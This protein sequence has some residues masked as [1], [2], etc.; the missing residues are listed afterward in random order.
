MSQIFI[1]HKTEQSLWALLV[2]L[3]L[4]FS[5]LKS[6]LAI[7]DADIKVQPDVTDYLRKQIMKCTDLLVVVD[8]STQKSWWVP[9]EVGIATAEDKRIVTYLPES[10]VH[11]PSYL[12]KWPV[13][14]TA[15]DLET[16]IVAIKNQ[17]LTE[18]RLSK[19]AS[20]EVF[21]SR[22]RSDSFHES[23]KKSLGQ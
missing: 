23:L 7:T 2:Q 6:F 17:E 15:D 14:R 8:E 10:S 19:S 11:L 4:I 21:G 16:W 5:G 20:Y 3:F 22:R 1:S 12:R 13:L 18:S 9:F